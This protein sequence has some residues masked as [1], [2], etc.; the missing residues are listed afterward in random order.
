[1][2]RRVLLAGLVPVAARAATLEGA[3]FPDTRT[4]DGT[5]LRLNGLAARTYTIFNVTVYVAALYLEQPGRDAGAIMASP[6]RK[7]VEVRYRRSVDEDDVRRAWRALLEANCGAA[8]GLGREI[9]RF[10]ALSP[11]VRDGS[12][13][14]YLV[15]A[16]GTVVLAD[17][18]RLGEVPGATFGRLLLATFIGAHPTS[19]G[20]RAG[21]LGLR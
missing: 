7:L 10:L 20:V 15:G 8:C 14:D 5:V 1:M 18:R 13:G 4:V 11:A 6:G 17:G 21:L 3:E 9:E 16:G 12:V 19:E 2:R